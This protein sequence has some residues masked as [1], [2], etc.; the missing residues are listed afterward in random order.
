M[1][2]N[3]II[4][5]PII[6]S[7]FVDKFEN[8]KNKYSSDE[9]N[10]DK[11]EKIFINL[12]K[13]LSDK[14]IEQDN[15]VKYYYIFI[16]L[17][18]AYTNY[19]GFTNHP[20]NPNNNSK[21]NIIIDKIKTSNKIVRNIFRFSQNPNVCQIIKLN[22]IYMLKKI[23]KCKNKL[24]DECVEDFT[25]TYINDIKQ[26]DKISEL[27]NGNYRKILNLIIYRYVS[28]KNS[29][30][31]NYN[32]FYTKKIISHQ[33]KI[34]MENFN[35]FIEQI[36]QSKKILNMVI[37]DNNK[38]NNNKQ[39]H[40]TN[41]KIINII[42]F[43]LSDKNKFY[44]EH[45]SKNKIL[46]KNK[47][48]EGI[49]QIN[50]M[51]NIST[52][53]NANT[54]A[55][56]N[57]EFNQYQTNYS[58]V[59]YNVDELADLNF[60]K[61]TFGNIE[62]NINSLILTD[63]SSILEFIHLLICAI[64]IISLNPSDLYECLYPIDYTN[65]YYD[66]FC[67][68][69]NFLKPHINK[70]KS[71]NKFIIDIYKFLFIYSYFDYYFYYSNNLMD[72]IIEKIEFKN[73]IFID[74]LGN[75]KNVLK[76]PKELLPFPPFF[77]EE[78]DVNSIL[79][80]N[81]EIPSYFKFFDFVKAIHHCLGKN[82]NNCVNN[83]INIIDVITENINFDNIDMFLNSSVLKSISVG[84]NIKLKNN[85]RESVTFNELK[86][87]KKLSKSSDSSN[88]T[89]SS[90]SSNSIN[91]SDISNT[92]ENSS[93]DYESSSKSADLMSS[94][95]ISKKTKLKKDLESNLDSEIINMLSIKNIEQINKPNTY[96]EISAN[97][98]MSDFM[99]N[100]EC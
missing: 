88:S 87:E 1:S 81:Y 60:L 51:E 26:F 99:L 25:Q 54:N 6:I 16:F 44:I 38:N 27:S 74:F 98:N 70:N 57:I 40:F 63:L 67:T 58:F 68:F 43:V 10:W 36:S 97:P 14:N 49:I 23:S 34:E 69:I 13:I 91:S 96:L 35:F 79:Y 32:D 3:N 39:N 29:N 31:K 64:K 42:N 17:Y 2:E 59:H 5:N 61:K 85:T 92:S 78:F 66:T 28:C 71:C 19:L 8:I 52:G 41:V 75:L 50:M 95:I 86:Q 62:I 93:E 7:L 45:S 47:K 94:E 37:S 73:D 9:F 11:F 55:S 84:N 100:T 15:F 77:N 80:Y 72:T 82:K 24:N 65:Y 56:T 48:S 21:I 4:L 89:N 76:L 18:L 90:N 53:T 46:I 30:Y 83:N 33:S 20:D 22:N 12:Q